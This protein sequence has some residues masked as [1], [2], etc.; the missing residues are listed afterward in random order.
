MSGKQ[1]HLQVLP[2]LFGVISWIRQWSPGCWS[3]NRKCMG[4]KGVTVNLQNYIG[5]SGN[6]GWATAWLTWFIQTLESSGKYLSL[7]LTVLESAGKGLDPGKPWKGHRKW[8]AQGVK[9]NC[10]VVH[11]FITLTNVGWF[12]KFLHCYILCKKFA[13]KPMPYCPPH[14]YFAKYIRLKLVKFCHI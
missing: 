9:N 11:L 6:L 3:G 10:A 13:T 4:P 2:K 7:K 14:H 5:L 1:I 12:S 8:D